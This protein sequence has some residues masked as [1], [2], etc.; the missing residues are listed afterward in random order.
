MEDLVGKKFGRVTILKYLGTFTT[1]HYEKYMCQC[2]CG[3]TMTMNYETL[4]K[5]PKGCASCRVKASRN[6]YNSDYRSDSH[7]S[8]IPFKV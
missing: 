7:R 2:D 1:K 6:F 5:N 4:I 8:D 3:D